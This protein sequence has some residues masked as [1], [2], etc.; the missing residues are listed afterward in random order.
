MKGCK[1]SDKNT[2][3]TRMLEEQFEKEKNDILCGFLK[4][5]EIIEVMH[6][7]EMT[8][9]AKKFEQE[10][11]FMRSQFELEMKNLLKGFQ[12]QQVEKE[13]EQVLSETNEWSE[14]STKKTELEERDLEIQ[15]KK[16]RMKLRLEFEEII[17][18]KNEEIKILRRKL[19]SEGNE[20]NALSRNSPDN[21][22]Y[23]KRTEHEE[24][25]RRFTETFETEKLE[26]QR[27]CDREKADLVQVFANQTERMN[28]K[29]DEQKKKMHED[30][31]KELKFKLE[32][33]ERLLLEKSDIDN[34][35]M[36][37]QFEHE[38]RDLQE[39]IEKDYKDR[40]LN[41]QET[42]DNLE[43]EKIDLV[44][45]MQTERFS[46]AKLYNREVYL[47]TKT[48][49]ITQ[50]K[51]DL[52]VVL[53]DEIAKL[54][55]QYEDA[56]S[57]MDKQQKQQVEEVKRKQKPER[58]LEQKHR[59]EME[60]LKRDFLNEKE[61]ME[62]EFR[63]EQL[64]LLKSFEFEKNDMEQKYEA[65]IQE[66]EAEI[67]Q[68]EEDLQR[69]YEEEVGELK[70]IV[71]KQREELDISKEKLTDLADQMEEFVS[72]RNRLEERIAKEKN[73]C[74]TLEKIVEKNLK[75]F[76]NKMKVAEEIY[77]KELSL[78]DDDLSTVKQKTHQLEA[79]NMNLHETIEALNATLEEVQTPLAG[80]SDLLQMDKREEEYI[81]GIQTRKD[82]VSENLLELREKLGNCIPVGEELTTVEDYQL[83][84]KNMK[85]AINRAIIA[86]DNLCSKEGK[87]KNVLTDEEP[88]FSIEDQLE[89]VE[90]ILKESDA[91][92]KIDE[93]TKDQINYKMREVLKKAHRVAQLEKLMLK[94]QDEEEISA[95][96]KELADEKGK[97]LEEMLKDMP[98]TKKTAPKPISEEKGKLDRNR[99]KVQSG[100]KTS[101]G[102]RKRDP[103]TSDVVDGL[104][105]E[106][107][108]LKRSIKELRN[109]FQREKEDLIEKLQTQHKEFMMS[110]ESE[111]IENVLKQKSSLEEA[112]HLERFCLSRLYY[113][114][115]KEELDDILDRRQENMKRKLEREKM[116][117][118]LKYE[119][120]ITDLHRLLSEKDEMEL[121]LLQDRNN[122]TQKLLVS[123]KRD[124]HEKGRRERKKE[125]Q[126]FEREKENLEVTIPL[127]REIA[128][129]QNKRRRE[130]ESYVAN[131]KEAINL[132]K[133][134]IS[135][136]PPRKSEDNRR[137][138]RASFYSEDSESSVARSPVHKGD[139][140]LVS[141]EE[142]RS[143][144]DL[145]AA[146][147]KLVDM[148]LN[149]NEEAVYD[150]ETTSGASS[151]L[152]SEYSDATVASGETD[153]GTF[154][155]PESNH[156][157]MLSVKRE[158]LDFV[159]NVERFN[160]GR[161]YYGEYRD[162]LRKAMK[163]LAKAKETIRSS[164][165][166]LENDLLR[167]VRSLVRRTNLGEEHHRVSTRDVDTQTVL[168]DSPH[169]VRGEVVDVIEEG[170]K[171][172]DM[173][174]DLATE[175]QLDNYFSE[176][177]KTHKK[178]ESCTPEEGRKD[179]SELPMVRKALTTDHSRKNEKCIGAR[180]QMG[181]EDETSNK[182]EEESAYGTFD[183]VAEGPQS[184]PN[185]GK[186]ADL[187]REESKEEEHSE[188]TGNEN[189][190][191]TNEVYVSF[192]TNDNGEGAVNDFTDVNEDERTTG[193]L[194]IENTN[195]I[196][197]NKTDAINVVG[198]KSQEMSGDGLN[199]EE[200][201]SRN[202]ICEKNED[203]NYV[204]ERREEDSTAAG[205]SQG[206]QTR[207]EAIFKKDERSTDD[208]ETCK[209]SSGQQAK[210]PQA[211]DKIMD[212]LQSQREPDKEDKASKLEA[213]PIN[214][215][216][217]D[218]RRMTTDVVDHEETSQRPQGNII[219]S[220]Q[221]QSFGGSSHNTNERNEPFEYKSEPEEV[222]GILPELK[223]LKKSNDDEPSS[224]KN[225]FETN[226]EKNGNGSE[227]FEETADV[228]HTK[229]PLGESGYQNE[230]H[231]GE[232]SSEL[233]VIISDDQEN[234][235]AE[236]LDEAESIGHKDDEITSEFKPQTQ[237]GEKERSEKDESITD[238]NKI[239][240]GTD[241][242]GGSEGPDF[243]EELPTGSRL[244]QK[245]KE[246]QTN[247]DR[248]GSEE[249]D[250]TTDTE[251]RYSNENFIVQPGVVAQQEPENNWNADQT[252]LGNDD[253]A[254]ESHIE[255]TIQNSPQEFKTAG[256][257]DE[258]QIKERSFEH[259]PQGSTSHKYE[260][261]VNSKGKIEEDV[262]SED[263]ETR[264]PEP[265]KEQNT[266]LKASV[267]DGEHVDNAEEGTFLE[268]ESTG[269]DGEPEKDKSNVS[270][271]KYPLNPN[272]YEEP[273]VKER[274]DIQ[275]KEREELLE[276][277][278]GSLKVKASNQISCGGKDA[279]VTG[280]QDDEAEWSSDYKNQIK[281]NKDDLEAQEFSDYKDQIKDSET[282]P[283]IEGFSDYK[284]KVKDNKSYP[285]AERSSDCK[286]QITDSDDYPETERSS[287]YKGNLSPETPMFSKATGA[288]TNDGDVAKSE[289]E[290]SFDQPSD[291]NNNF[292]SSTDYKMCN[293]NTMDSGKDDDTSNDRNPNAGNDKEKNDGP[294]TAKDSNS[295][296]GDE[297]DEERFTQNEQ[298]LINQL[299]RNNKILQDKFDLLCEIV[300][301]GFVNE[302]PELSEKQEAKDSKSGLKSV[303]DLHE[304]KELLSREREQVDLKIE[305]LHNSRVE[306]ME[307]DND[308]KE[309]EARILDSLEQIDMELRKRNEDHLLNHLK[310]ERKDVCTKLEEIDHLMQEEMDGVRNLPENDTF[311][312]FGA[313]MS[314]RDRLKDDALEKSRE[315]QRRSKMLEEAN[316]KSRKE[317][318]Q[319]VK[320]LNELKALI[321]VLEDFKEIDSYK[322]QAKM[323]KKNLPS[324]I[325]S[326]IGNK[327]GLDLKKLK[328]N[329][330][331]KKTA[332]DIERYDRLLDE[333]R[334]SLQ[335]F[336]RKKDRL[337]QGLHLLDPSLTTRSKM[338]GGHEQ[339]SDKVSQSI[340]SMSFGD[341]QMQREGNSTS[342]E[343]GVTEKDMKA[344][345]L[346]IS[347]TPGELKEKLCEETT[348]A[349]RMEI[350]HKETVQMMEQL[351]H[352]NAKIGSEESLLR[353]AGV[354]FPSE[355]TEYWE[356][357]LDMERGTLDNAQL[358]K[359]GSFSDATTHESKKLESLFLL[360]ES[361]VESTSGLE[362]EIS[363]EQENFLLV[364]Q[365]K[366]T[367]EIR[368]ET[369]CKIKVLI[370]TQM[371]LLTE[372]NDTNKMILQRISTGGLTGS[373][374][375][376]IEDSVA[377]KLRLEKDIDKMQD[378]MDGE[379]VRAA[380]ALAS[381]AEKKLPLDEDLAETLENIKVQAQRIQEAFT[382][383]HESNKIPEKIALLI[384]QALQIKQKESIS[385]KELR[386]RH[387]EV[388]LLVKQNAESLVEAKETGKN[389]S[390]EEEVLE[391]SIREK[392]T[393]D[394]QLK[395]VLR[396][397]SFGSEVF[398]SLQEE[399]GEQPMQNEGK[400]RS[401]PFSL[402]GDIEAESS[403]QNLKEGGRGVNS[404]IHAD[405]SRTRNLLMEV[406]LSEEE[407]CA[408]MEELRSLVIDTSKLKEEL[409]Q[410]KLIEELLNEGVTLEGKITQYVPQG[411]NGKRKEQNEIELVKINAI[412]EHKI[413]EMQEL[414]R[415]MASRDETLKQLQDAREELDNVLETLEENICKTQK[416]AKDD[417]EKAQRILDEQ[418]KLLGEEQ[419]ALRRELDSIEDELE[420]SRKEE[421]GLE[422]ELY[423]LKK[424]YHEDRQIKSDLEK[425]FIEKECLREYLAEIDTAIGNSDT[426][427]EQEKQQGDTLKYDQLTERKKALEKE[428][429][430]IRDLKGKTIV[431]YEDEEIEE[432]IKELTQRK[433][434]LQERE[435]EIYEEIRDSDMLSE[436]ALQAREQKNEIPLY[437]IQGILFEMARDK[438]TLTRFIKEQQDLNNAVQ[439]QRDELGDTI[440]LVKCKVG[441]KLFNIMTKSALDDDE[442]T[443]TDQY[444]SILSEV[445]GNDASIDEALHYLAEENEQLMAVNETMNLELEVLKDKVGEQLVTEL[446]NT[447]LPKEELEFDEVITATMKEGGFPLATILQEQKSKTQILEDT[448]G[449]GLFNCIV[450][451]NGITE[452]GTR[453]SYSSHPKLVAPDIMERFD[454]DLESVIA[455]YE[456]DLNNLS[457]EN[458]V[459]K[460]LLGEDLAQQLLRMSDTSEKLATLE[461]RIQ[462]SQSGPEDRNG[463]HDVTDENIDDVGITGRM[464]AKSKIIER[465]NHV[466]PSAEK[467][468]PNDVEVE[469]TEA[470]K[471][472]LL[473]RSSKRLDLQ[474][475]DAK[476]QGEKAQEDDSRAHWQS[477][478]LGNDSLKRGKEEEKME[479]IN[480]EELLQTE[481][482]KEIAPTLINLYLSHVGFP[483]E[484]NSYAL[485]GEDET[486]KSS[487]KAVDAIRENGETLGEI[488]VK[489]ELELQRAQENDA[490]TSNPRE[491]RK[492][493]PESIID[494]GSRLTEVSKME[495][496][497]Q[498]VIDQENTLAMLKE[499]LGE[500]LAEIL[501]KGAKQEF[502]QELPS[503]CYVSVEEDQVGNNEI[504]KHLEQ[505]PLAR[506]GDKR[507]KTEI[508][509]ER[510][511]S[512][513][514]EL[515]SPKQTNNAVAEDKRRL[516]GDEGADDKA[517]FRKLKA[518]GIALQNNQTLADVISLYEESLEFLQN[519]LGPSLTR[520]LLEQKP[521]ALPHHEDKKQEQALKYRE[522]DS[523]DKQSSEGDK[524]S[525]NKSE[526]EQN[527]GKTAVAFMVESFGNSLT[528]IDSRK[529]KEVKAP[530]VM[531]KSRKT[532][533]EVI[534]DYE[535]QI[536]INL[537]KLENEVSLL[538][539]KL[540]SNLLGIL[541]EDDSTENYILPGDQNASK[542]QETGGDYEQEFIIQI[543]SLIEDESKT[544]E[545]IIRKY[546]FQLKEM[547]RLVPSE[548]IEDT[549]TLD[550][551]SDLKDKISSLRDKYKHL[552]EEK[553]ILGEKLN[554]IEK[555]LGQGLF[556]L[557]DNI[558]D[559]RDQSSDVETNLTTADKLKIEDG[560]KTK[561]QLGEDTVES[562]HI[563]ARSPIQG[564]D[565]AQPDYLIS[566]IQN[567]GETI[568]DILRK[569]ER[570]LEDM[571]K[572]I[573]SE[574][575]E[576]V[577]VLDLI[578]DSEDTTTCIKSR[579]EDVEEHN[580][581]VETKL[582]N[583][584]KILGRGLFRVLENL[585][586][587]RQ[588]SG[589]V[590][591]NMNPTDEIYET[592]QEE[593]EG[594]EADFLKATLLMK[595]GKTVE[596]ILKEYERQLGEMTEFL[597]NEAGSVDSKEV[598]TS[599]LEHE[600]WRL[601]GKDMDSKK[602]NE[603][604][605]AKLRSIEKHLGKG[606][607]CLL[608]NL[609]D[610]SSDEEAD[611][612]EADKTNI[613]K[614]ALT[615][616]QL[617]DDDRE[618]TAQP[619]NLKARSLIE[620]DGKTMEE[621][622]L[623]YETQLEEMARL[624][625]SEKGNVATVMD[626]IS[627][628]EN[629]M[630][631]LKSKN[632]N[633]EQENKTLEER[634][635]N[636]GNFID[637]DRL[638]ALDNV[639]WDEGKSSNEV[640]TD[641]DISS[642]T[643]NEGP[644]T[645]S[646][647]TGG[648]EEEDEIQ[649]H[650]RNERTL[651]K[652]EDQTAEK[653]LLT[654]EKQLK[655][656]AK[657]FS[658][659]ASSMD[660][661]SDFE[662]G[663]LILKEQVNDTEDD[664]Q[665]LKDK[666]RNLEIIIGHDLFY[667]LN[668][669]SDLDS[670]SELETGFDAVRKLK[671]GDKT[672]EKVFID[673]ESELTA[674]RKLMPNPGK[675]SRSLSDVITEFEETNDQL[676]RENK[677]LKKFLDE[678]MDKI[679]SNLFSDL[680]RFL[681]T[682]DHS[683]E[684]DSSIDRKSSQKLWAPKRM[685]EETLTLEEVIISYE[686]DLNESKQTL[687]VLRGVSERQ[688]ETPLQAAVKE[689]R[690]S[691]EGFHRRHSFP[692]V[693]VDKE[694]SAFRTKWRQHDNT[695]RIQ[696]YQ[697]DIA[698]AA[699][700]NSHPFDGDFEILKSRLGHSLAEE[701]MKM[702]YTISASTE[703]KPGTELKITKIMEVKQS[704][705]E[706]V[707]ETYESA[708]GTLLSDTP[709][710]AG[711]ADPRNFANDEKTIGKVVTEYEEDTENM[712]RERAV[713][714][715]IAS[716]DS[717]TSCL[718][719][720]IETYEN[721]ISTL[722]DKIRSQDIL[723]SKVGALLSKQ[724]IGL[725]TSTDEESLAFFSLRAVEVMEKD[726]D[727]TLADVV[728]NYEEELERKSHEIL[729]L[730]ELISG[731]MLEIATSQEGEIYELKNVNLILAKELEYL[732]DQ[733]GQEL[734][735][736][737]LKK[738][739]KDPLT[740]NVKLY[741]EVIN[742]MDM[743][744]KKLQ[745]V[746]E[747]LDN[748][749][750]LMQGE[751]EVL[752]R[753]GKMLEE[754]SR[755]VGE[756]L[757]KELNEDEPKM[758]KEA[759]KPMFEV[760][761]LMSVEQKT[762]G[763]VI[764]SYEID[765]VRLRRENEAFCALMEKESM[766]D[767]PVINVLSDYEEKISK[768]E[769]E[770]ADQCKTIQ[771]LN[772][773]IGAE[774]SQE[775][776]TLPNEPHASSNK[777]ASELKA[778]EIIQRDKSSLLDV[779]I[780]YEK[781]LKEL[782]DDGEAGSL[783]SVQPAKKD[784]MKFAQLIPNV[785]FKSET[786]FQISH[787][788]PSEKSGDD[789]EEDKITNQIV[790]PDGNMISKN[791]QSLDSLTV[792][793]T[794]GMDVLLF[795]GF[796]EKK[797]ETLPHPE[798]YF[799]L[800]EPKQIIE[801]N[802]VE[803]QLSQHEESLNTDFVE[804]L[805]ASDRH[806][807]DE[808]ADSKRSS[809]LKIK[810]KLEEE[811]CMELENLQ[812][813]I[814]QLEEELEEEKSL[815]KQYEKDAQDLLK[816]IVVLK[817]K[818][819]EDGDENP[820]ESRRIM[821]EELEIKQDNRHLEEDLRIERKRRV[822]AEESKRDLVDEVDNLMKQKEALLER[823]K[824]IDQTEKL[825]A[826]T[827]SLRRKIGEQNRINKKLKEEL[828]EREKSMK[829]R[830]ALHNEEK[831]EL[832]ANH[833][834][835]KSEL[836]QELVASKETLETQLKELFAM[837][838]DLKGTIKILQD[839]LKESNETLESE[840]EDKTEKDKYE[841]QLE[842]LYAQNAKREAELQQQVDILTRQ[843]EMERE[844]ARKQNKELENL[845][846][847]KEH[848]KEYI[849]LKLEKQ[850]CDFEET[851]A[852][853]RRQDA[854]SSVDLLN[855]EEKRNKESEEMLE[856]LQIERA[857]IQEAFD[858]EL[859]RIISEKEEEQRLKDEQMNR[860]FLM[861][862]RE[863]K[864]I[865]E[866]EIYEQLIDK[867]LETEADF[868]ELL[869]RILQEHS[870]EI[871]GVENDI[872]KA[873]E[874]FQDEKER[875]IEQSDKEKNVLKE[876]Y[877][878]EKKALQA[879]VQDLLKEVIKLKNQRKELRLSHKIEIENMEVT[880]EKDILKLKENW[881]AKK[882]DL[883]NNLKQDFD[884]KVVNETGK[885]E[886][887]LEELQR[888]LNKSEQR[889]K[890][891]EEQ[892]KETPAV[893]FHQMIEEEASTSKGNEDRINN[894]KDL[895]PVK[896]KLEEE[897]DKKLSE[898]KR[899]FE[900]ILVGLRHE[901]GN[902]QEKRRVI[903]DKLYGHDPTS[904][905]KQLMEKSLTN[906][907]MEM[908]SKMEKEVEQ[909]VA[910]EKEPLEEAINEMQREVDDLKRQRWELRNQ[911]R[912]ERAKMEEELEMEREHIQ[913]QFL[914][915]KEDLKSKLDSRVQKELAKRAAEN[916]ISRALSPIYTDPQ[917]SPRGLRSENTLLRGDNQRLQLEVSELQS[918]LG[919][920]EFSIQGMVSSEKMK[921]EKMKQIQA[922]MPKKVT[923]SDE[924]HARTID[925]TTEISNETILQQLREKDDQVKQLLEAKRF[926]EEVLSELCEEAG[927]FEL[928]QDL[929]I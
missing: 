516:D 746:L 7:E 69:V 781:K 584:G 391:N 411:D 108:H 483:Q 51:E 160:L 212:I 683:F 650:D 583:I 858:Q 560:T 628:S 263:E 644:E 435:N 180:T 329:K 813:K 165:K 445:T 48:D 150:S 602:E 496:D 548:T 242:L 92:G 835:E 525:M 383:D 731:D 682:H 143:K 121:R 504:T 375:E 645:R 144:E 822:S 61:C 254:Y 386:Q 724:L 679:G 355:I 286:D 838:E 533:E 908:L 405:D 661:R 865:I 659:D 917:D 720:R 707:L 380:K 64:N 317:D 388:E 535:R 303:N 283:D 651:T 702:K 276:T 55:Q 488:V 424:E 734:S 654:K 662:D 419:E 573:P 63:K 800:A 900:E 706:D 3:E 841:D 857:K 633:L 790:I 186:W 201:Y 882:R 752:S 788:A 198:E 674:L 721:E 703:N 300:G 17:A 819:I 760:S 629:E 459:Y 893:N 637:Q 10:K 378:E 513:E 820:E 360:R 234:F 492:N 37:E 470:I 220:L 696:V 181:N 269:H 177:L 59:K 541:L 485:C 829:G 909:K 705:L 247:D 246:V 273:S 253:L 558:E 648:H 687:G 571:R 200:K 195:V 30:Q 527:D 575:G 81:Q 409:Q 855:Q 236:N 215:G 880:Y 454:E 478:E 681:R 412:I 499:R 444:H 280:G 190:Q 795:E 805:F 230:K 761:N 834:K 153:E 364:R 189:I 257:L 132:M 494:D 861:E 600:P 568:E 735:D 791:G 526:K 576:S 20:E 49:Q 586:A 418:R 65:I 907:K 668:K 372:L 794:I 94:K 309:A 35:R 320:S 655:D 836:M 912:R 553:S 718:M 521:Y 354:E 221:N 244:E 625:P 768:L 577:A 432:T 771:T 814:K 70:M 695:D 237:L 552:E 370:D 923:F 414:Q 783:V 927:F 612:N 487:L 77:Q 692:S 90:N 763:E 503:A 299:K 916:K 358:I 301:K 23:I 594:K 102:R 606:L 803:V 906:Y 384:N 394:G 44:N 658:E 780:N 587:R 408:K 291:S 120:D 100:P 142:I 678:L 406:G 338:L 897:Y 688:V 844:F 850:Q 523:E 831:S 738:S 311:L 598:V 609:H 534:E 801:E 440:A 204:N 40:L 744:G 557:L 500:D 911:M 304:E 52:E 25:L 549:P 904:M 396:E 729:N 294:E 224:K 786:P 114:E 596:D 43:K 458:K 369:G 442:A 2:S 157:E 824:E 324:D 631:T 91:S 255:G 28:A 15:C 585:Q 531:A 701:I 321:D 168:K 98:E 905:D 5:K 859:T 128:E 518:P 308:G 751:I 806:A 314:K 722:N 33:T 804:N 361:L 854:K 135:S 183:S 559:K 103:S 605:E 57:E 357:G 116:D 563:K 704:T 920:L 497:M 809:P 306:E 828:M 921:A 169:P 510:L 249:D 345:N 554:N 206:I 863:L 653:S 334:K 462:Y 642:K 376:L 287:D 797:L 113:S 689:R 489:Y 410:L 732:T 640:N 758:T 693:E 506:N 127:K 469:F 623:T 756:D 782:D 539:E 627:D 167:C 387:Q 789:L 243:N 685:E 621:I 453:G 843:L 133:E 233:D 509:L 588:L 176:D 501:I 572:L 830:E 426:D 80:K 699:E 547:T 340:A 366:K 698:D 914:K 684:T 275:D 872:Q 171:M 298:D 241:V 248:E 465:E 808:E 89:A 162:S 551:S 349:K 652:N 481:T 774:L 561:S 799:L 608:D 615:K 903:Q 284:D 902:L 161:V 881:E 310:K 170:Q 574:K 99:D 447:D 507:S 918:K 347:K 765:L 874:R 312:L 530:S 616:S 871:E 13:R 438:K 216:G 630:A 146:L 540:G 519:Q 928:D 515:L 34:K 377:K 886:I 660:L 240:T 741:R 416:K 888:E 72:E 599:E 151:D 536:Y 766:E 546:E 50:T 352:L 256:N 710:S 719:E 331:L 493:K 675:E 877:E 330:K 363:R 895:T 219:Y 400:S 892:L 342:Q 27:K 350:L 618:D 677:D 31:Q 929:V 149:T 270:Q 778:L 136:T 302:I 131:L 638:L 491:V 479:R 437:A 68:R 562:D 184:P 339:N 148:I 663:K 816:D 443:I 528:E 622:L 811:E 267:N 71:S 700:G 537:S 192:E 495:T 709:A 111:V 335:P 815:K 232:N 823:Q 182:K 323:I 595:D 848:L 868:R 105:Q 669:I 896:K 266:K 423:F 544:V 202:D 646:E 83:S 796:V 847:E 390:D 260:E 925:Y 566:L 472:V 282:Y 344:L 14:I 79:E 864:A 429:G 58:E 379:P 821:Q 676:L 425:L 96:L 802:I 773:R 207:D 725:S 279:Q 750:T 498:G 723:Q 152:E 318:E 582:R 147:E 110:S 218:T 793:E 474:E 730:K 482:M 174:V 124:T 647:P 353:K 619:C 449:K 624:F 104:E 480:P 173:D 359:D 403:Q 476:I 597:P 736:E 154:S 381:L 613:D 757:F 343:H 565:T 367:G 842:S 285:E 194:D 196:K 296:Q 199:I 107:E 281:N 784:E 140:I 514:T 581:I 60:K 876:I 252:T 427:F 407:A 779:L 172:I 452:P 726:E 924:V 159:F 417:F 837:N 603:I 139:E 289:Q 362:D 747:D 543:R 24:E 798:E 413:K 118:I 680:T 891:V 420:R 441:E 666:L 84:N 626:L 641:C 643:N 368:G 188:K 742:K 737:L 754:L 570:E 826:D 268:M 817:M 898:E 227:S 277:E 856:L 431:E 137:L 686:K 849:D 538:K 315:L 879:T 490:I 225:E 175:K 399:E 455:I 245:S 305:Q 223:S 97:K 145:L 85:D 322:Y 456:K 134:I 259:E 88:M 21:D 374:A 511:S 589:D 251:E 392:M 657:L 75:A 213:V 569:Y 777:G 617:G 332:N 555:L 460:K 812:K 745:S 238:R 665:S 26:L 402:I 473:T 333:K 415:R 448:L 307:N 913:R 9:L 179:S 632:K 697:S 371:D 46:L 39:S 505:D 290:T 210:A 884:T 19:L 910:R 397:M 567:D 767:T 866:R 226:V 101:K 878:D 93:I 1:V 484:K 818:Q 326:L 32:V 915:E 846:R 22:V 753:N 475:L 208:K 293:D 614:G 887:E 919:A 197:L 762:L 205:I 228:C 759:D 265:H 667:T 404:H 694:T 451:S 852:E 29:F 12:T 590:E 464:D 755:K 74:Q 231:T 860:E 833:E 901:I 691:T 776:L 258:P 550:L 532:L 191:L 211:E 292:E 556:C 129:L 591:I 708:L 739:D 109:T 463:M 264:S 922:N 670:S 261:T 748:E 620:N 356:K 869:S 512:S 4:E 894:L 122:V 214:N 178:E 690:L 319:L 466:V 672:L 56:M 271:P 217:K 714:K 810:L 45:A 593:H 297:D 78:K 673:Y 839:Q 54:K 141:D 138:D 743:D 899:K 885:L 373:H 250:I 73:Q 351:K 155:G 772:Q 262:V 711:D 156:G 477:E 47:L 635:R 889:R 634:L 717:D 502:S 38:V 827:T 422:E 450:R 382:N 389:T 890:E 272:E 126:Q 8:A 875:L 713:Q 209:D 67:E 611:F 467:Q 610:R 41:Q 592:K 564:D 346:A 787:I 428:L 86:I 95:L 433:H 112:F 740:D 851:K 325:E 434:D 187:H 239:H 106:N 125:K 6:T 130:H 430:D 158:K 832:L 421:R 656:P 163:K 862:K 522:G 229:K 716:K 87:D 66:R 18:A 508:K 715:D 636:V 867:N 807:N 313:L 446:L 792:S 873:E 274:K 185:N 785:E 117:L 664:S 457:R 235:K 545:D 164:R 639:Q 727:L 580:E 733:I 436:L 11:D 671:N 337:E 461:G 883:L 123:Q 712:E 395:E 288:G 398:S 926:Y 119:S 853:L 840:V 62:A 529:G 764:L 385:V 439:K 468:R 316:R 348:T 336:Q 870:K 471:D 486:V 845:H 542:S 341:D 82:N 115:M 222:K 42:I 604:F 166:D 775:L 517:N 16:E 520:T 53:L 770:N 327:M 401:E 524:I 607:F 36:L 728:K 328:L 203:Q 193:Q 365:Y 579:K 749:R 295:F 769:G 76:E 601:K 825:L 393:V 278:C 578:S 649:L